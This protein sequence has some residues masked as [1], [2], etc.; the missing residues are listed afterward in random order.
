KGARIGESERR[1]LDAIFSHGGATVHR[2]GREPLDP[3]NATDSVPHEPRR[4]DRMATGPRFLSPLR[5]SGS[6]DGGPGSWSRGSRPWRL[7]AA[8]PWL[9][10]TSRIASELLPFRLC[11]WP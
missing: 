6:E 7:T 4:G 10:K 2:Q 5:G 11:P 3:Q 1:S 9:K 8:P